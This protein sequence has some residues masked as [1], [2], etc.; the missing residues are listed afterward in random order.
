ML[1]ED[2]RVWTINKLKENNLAFKETVN[3]GDFLAWESCHRSIELDYS[4]IT[5]EVYGDFRG[6]IE[7]LDKKIVRRHVEDWVL[8]QAAIHG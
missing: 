3:D 2:K 7:R 6:L 8:G 4:V 5:A 1:S